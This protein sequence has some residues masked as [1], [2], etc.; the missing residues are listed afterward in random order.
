MIYFITRHSGALE[1]LQQQVAEPAVHISHLSDISS[2]SHGDTVIGTLPVNLVAT[3]CKRGVRYLHLEV[4]PP[5]HLRGQELSAKQ[6]SELDTVLVEYF[7][8]APCPDEWI[9]ERACELE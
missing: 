2:I 5:P 3:L 6:L 9:L 1:W 7:A 8:Y 4:S